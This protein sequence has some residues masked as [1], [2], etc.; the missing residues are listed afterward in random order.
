[1]KK[2]ITE[3]IKQVPFNH[4]TLNHF[5]NQYQTSQEQLN[6][7]LSDYDLSLEAI[8][9]VFDLTPK[10]IP[11]SEARLASLFTNIQCQ[12]WPETTSVLDTIKE[13]PS[14]GVKLHVAEFQSCGQGTKNRS[15]QSGYGQGINFA[16]QFHVN[17]TMQQMMG[18]SQF[19][20]L[21]LHQLFNDCAVKPQLKWPNDLYYQGKKLA[22]VLINVDDVGHGH[23]K[24]TIGIGMN[25]HPPT[26]QIEAIGLSSFITGPIDRH[27]WLVNYIEIFN[28]N[29]P[30]FLS[31]Q[32]SPWLSQWQNHDMLYSKMCE[33]QD[34]NTVLLKKVMGINAQ[35]LICLEDTAGEMKTSFTAQIQN[36]LEER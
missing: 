21:M 7:D 14:D 18:L 11:W 1:M 30:L 5:L 24:V 22:G 23:V 29:L 13:A 20:I 12:V 10:F 15:W 27:E 8:G 25:V 28:K 31:H 16:W 35:G 6:Q 33:I 17:A 19:S 3:L 36:V 26:K 34:Q 2:L 32:L 4:E 9:D